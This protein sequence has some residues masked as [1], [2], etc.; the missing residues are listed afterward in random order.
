M[1]LSQKELQRVKVIENAVEGRLTVGQASELLGL[2]ERQVKRLKAKY[3]T[4]SVEWVKNGNLRRKKPWG[5]GQA[6]AGRIVELAREVHTG[7]NNSHFTEKLVEVEEIEVSRETVSFFNLWISAH[8]EG[9]VHGAPACLADIARPTAKGR[10][11]KRDLFEIAL[12][13]GFQARDAPFP[14]GLQMRRRQ[15]SHNAITRAGPVVISA[16]S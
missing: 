4:E 10:H 6:V 13:H 15:E 14:P 11:G 16:I 8:A 2:S 1:D 3:E 7:F 12:N 5:L 9:E